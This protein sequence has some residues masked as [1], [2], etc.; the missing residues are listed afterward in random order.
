MPLR[1]SSGHTHPATTA[2]VSSPLS[3]TQV[4]LVLGDCTLIGL[5]PVLVHMAK[6]K[7]GHYPFRCEQLAWWTG[8][9]S[10]WQRTLAGR[11]WIQRQP[12]RA[13]AVC[14]H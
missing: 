5:A 14:C 13:A 1:A 6:D 4:W 2:V 12:A 3:Y 10:C 9:D 7:D 8:V 11:P